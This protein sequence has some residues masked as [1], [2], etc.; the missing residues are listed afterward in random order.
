MTD[1]QYCI[2]PS[3]MGGMIWKDC[4]ERAEEFVSRAMAVN[5]KSRDDIQALLAASAKGVRYDTEWYA[6]LRNK[7]LG[8]AAEAA[9][10]AKAEANK[11]AMQKTKCRSCGEYLSASRFT[12]L[13]ASAQTCDDCA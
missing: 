5:G 3:G 13:P 8:E 12:T 11:K 2:G 7:A 6:S 4:G 10:R 9:M 1:L